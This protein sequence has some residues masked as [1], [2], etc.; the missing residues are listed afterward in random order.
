MERCSSILNASHW[1]CQIS[2][3]MLCVIRRPAGRSLSVHATQ[4]MDGY[5]LK[6]PTRVKASP[7]S[8][9]SASLTNSFG[10]L[11]HPQAVL[12]WVSPLP[13]RS[14]RD[15]MATLASKAKLDEGAPSGL[16]CHLRRH[17][18]SKAHSL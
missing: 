16:H 1:Y 17:P 2:S 14:C 3:P 15:T 4:Q 7:E 9:S 11:V 6:S 12:V 5:A 13:R 18:A 8:T 10:C